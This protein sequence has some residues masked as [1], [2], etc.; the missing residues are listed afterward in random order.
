MSENMMEVTVAMPP[1]PIPAKALAAMSSSIV[2]AKPQNRHPSPKTAYANKRV[3]FLPKMSL[4][5]PYSGWNVVKVRKYLNHELS[6]I[7]LIHR[8]HYIRCSYPT[9]AIQGVQFATN[10][11]IGADNNCLIRSG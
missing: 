11:A 1:P 8:G 3:D 9:G 7:E 4:S 6:Y 10:P 2:R 5:L